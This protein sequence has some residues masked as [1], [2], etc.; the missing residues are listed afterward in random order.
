WGKIPIRVGVRNDPKVFSDL[1]DV[2]I[3]TTFMISVIDYDIGEVDT[4]GIK[5]IYYKAKETDQVQGMVFT[6]GT[7]IGWKQIMFDIA[8]EYSSYETKAKGTKFGMPFDELNERKDHRIFFNFTGL[9]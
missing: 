2:V 8:Y 7:G 3:D 9:F 6:L 1:S 4:I 5:N